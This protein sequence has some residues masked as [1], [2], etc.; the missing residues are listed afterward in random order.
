MPKPRTA[1]TAIAPATTGLRTP[2]WRRGAPIDRSPT[3]VSLAIGPS[4]DGFPHIGRFAPE[5]ERGPAPLL[6]SPS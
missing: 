3:R 1:T 6:A 5:L 4:A 2:T